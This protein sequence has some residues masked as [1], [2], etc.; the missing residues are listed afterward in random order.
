MRSGDQKSFIQRTAAVRD[1]RTKKN[2]RTSKDRHLFRNQ[3]YRHL[4]FKIN[5]E[6]FVMRAY[7]LRF[8]FNLRVSVCSFQCLKPQRARDL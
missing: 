6:K 7:E 5:D 4:F 8:L 2:I 1:S 3:L